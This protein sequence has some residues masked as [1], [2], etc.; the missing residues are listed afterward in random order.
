[1]REGRS[2][3]ATALTLCQSYTP[4]KPASLLSLYSTPKR[5][6]NRTY[7]FTSKDFSHHH[8]C[9]YFISISKGGDN[10]IQLKGSE[11]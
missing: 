11:S 4:A 10:N 9:S 2:E 7:I 3:R 8:S 5:A 6:G 1:M